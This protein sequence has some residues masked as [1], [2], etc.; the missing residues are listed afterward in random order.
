[1][2]LPGVWRFWLIGVLMGALPLKG[3]ALAV[4]LACC[5]VV[6]AHAHSAPAAHGA[7]VHAQ[8]SGVVPAAVGH[9]HPVVSSDGPAAASKHSAGAEVTHADHAW[10][11]GGDRPV[12][13]APLCCTAASMSPPAPLRFAPKSVSAPPP[14]LA[15]RLY[16]SAPL[17]GIE[18][19]PKPRF[20]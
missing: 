7:V 9:A 10:P 3:F 6:P 8:E 20:A 1:M 19:P 13:K 18:H 17:P 14:V 15:D 4:M 16:R 2:R 12:A 5:P 11:G